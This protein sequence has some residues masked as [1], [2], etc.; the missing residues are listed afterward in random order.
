MDFS[1]HCIALTAIAGLAACGGNNGGSDPSTSADAYL[2]GAVTADA[3]NGGVI[4]TAET[5]NGGTIDPTDDVVTAVPGYAIDSSGSVT[6]DISSVTEAGS[7]TVE[8]DGQTYVLSGLNTVSDDGR[9][10]NLAAASANGDA[11]IVTILG[12]GTDLDGMGSP[13]ELYAYTRG[14]VT[15]AANLPSASTTYSGNANFATVGSSDV[16][17]GTFS[18]TVGF[19]DGSV[20]GDV[21]LTAFEGTISGAQSGASVTGTISVDGSPDTMDLSGGIF[22]SAGEEFAGSAS[23]TVD[24]TAGVMVLQGN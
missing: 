3:T 18:L 17:E 11:S 21:D 5:D 13:D 24:G 19:G 10:E 2:S 1:R 16:D 15:D 4:G 9:L 23:G 20:S 7:T 22:G 6:T 8:I 12:T 14:L